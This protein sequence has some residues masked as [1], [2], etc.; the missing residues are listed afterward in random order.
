MKD[1]AEQAL[2][3]D[4]RR[5]IYLL[6]EEV[7]GAHFREIHRR[8]KIPT[9]VVEYHLKYL[10]NLDMVTFRMEGR[11]KRYYVSGRLGSADKSLMS[12]LRQKV[13]RRI[14]MFV[15]LNPGVNHRELTRAMEVSP[16]TL[17]YHMKKLMSG[18]I[19]NQMREGRQNLYWLADEEKVIRALMTYREGFMDDVVDAFAETWLDIHP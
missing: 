3:L 9:S 1:E 11:Y 17:S 4:T 18:G 6:L 12:L 14:I 8:L 2:E 19:I 15:A 5:R 10:E 7:P 13:P 16:S